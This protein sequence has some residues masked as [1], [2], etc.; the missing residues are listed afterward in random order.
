MLAMTTKVT[1]RLDIT[2]RK[3]KTRRASATANQTAAMI[4]TKPKRKTMQ[5]AAT[6]PRLAQALMSAKLLRLSLHLAA[7]GRGFNMEDI[8]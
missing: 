7:A 3:V 5:R 2:T 6:S 4:M 8:R 1:T